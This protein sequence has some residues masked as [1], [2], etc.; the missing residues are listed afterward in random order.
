MFSDFKPHVLGVPDNAKLAASD[1]GVA[2][3]YAFR[4]P[5]LRNLRYT[6]PYMHSGAFASLPD[7]LRFYNGAGRRP[8]NP[9]VRADQLDPLLRQLNTGRGFEIIDFLDA[10]NDDTFDKRTPA[11]VPSGLHPGGNIRD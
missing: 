8:R 6:A 7:V 10:L 11:R 3:W 5:S 4:T 9:N 2:D 1:A